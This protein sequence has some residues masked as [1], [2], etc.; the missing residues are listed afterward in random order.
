MKS[1]LSIEASKKQVSGINLPENTK[2]RKTY[3]E[4]FLQL[5]IRK[6]DAEKRA[7]LFGMDPFKS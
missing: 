3:Y 7:Q 5:L 1:N 6:T 4:Q 2:K